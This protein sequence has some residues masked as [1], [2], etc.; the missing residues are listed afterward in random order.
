MVSIRSNRIVDHLLAAMLIYTVSCKP[1]T[2]LFEIVIYVLYLD[3]YKRNFSICEKIIISC[4]F[5]C[6]DKVHYSM[7]LLIQYHQIVS[8]SSNIFYNFINIF[9]FFE[10][11]ALE[12]IRKVL[13]LVT[14]NKA[15]TLEIVIIAATCLTLQL[16][17][18]NLITKNTKRKIFHFF[19]F[20]YFCKITE[21]KIEIALYSIFF[22]LFIDTQFNTRRLYAEFVN[23]KD[24]GEY[25][26]SH[27]FI[28]SACTFPYFFLTKDEYI[29]TIIAVCI[30][31]AFASFG[32]HLAKSKSKTYFGFICG[33]ISAIITHY[34]LYQNYKHVFYFLFIG[35]IELYTHQND[36]IVIPFVSVAW[37]NMSK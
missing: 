32:G 9:A 35:L 36:N 11:V 34:I 14:K 6:L 31:D 24:T 21:Y 10:L 18:R 13:V 7:I 4:M 23:D 15:E 33:V 19:V 1:L 17:L 26:M 5:S 30:Q 8:N 29:S 3:V 25:V 16:L 22:F 2:C 12:E 28:L 20:I 27:I 37:F